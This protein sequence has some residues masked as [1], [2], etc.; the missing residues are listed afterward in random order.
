MHDYMCNCPVDP[1]VTW[2]GYSIRI[3]QNPIKTLPKNTT[4]VIT[5]FEIETHASCV[6]NHENFCSENMVAE[7]SVMNSMSCDTNKTYIE[8]LK[9][10]T[11][12][13]SSINIRSY[14]FKGR[15][16]RSIYEKACKNIIQKMIDNF[17][18]KKKDS[19]NDKNP[20]VKRRQKIKDQ[21][22]R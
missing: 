4:Y 13:T 2:R 19:T 17:D 12:D 3:A 5:M 10:Y 16:D 6:K 9:K 7:F 20:H 14:G 8:L 18:E 21:R 11:Q 15:V 22:H 1:R